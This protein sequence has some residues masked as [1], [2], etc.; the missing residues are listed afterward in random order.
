MQA[1]KFKT[2]K[3]TT[4]RTTPPLH[5]IYH[6]TNLIMRSRPQQPHI[7]EAYHRAPS[8]ASLS[9]NPGNYVIHICEA[10]HRPVTSAS[11][12]KT[13]TNQ[14]VQNK[15]K[16]VGF[17]AGNAGQTRHLVI[18]H[19]RS[20]PQSALVRFGVRKSRK[21]RLS[22]LRSLPQTRHI[23]FAGQNKHKPAGFT[24]GNAGQTR[25]LVT[26]LNE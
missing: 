3:F 17:T 6:H 1:N 8:C 19:P 21:P 23:R 20:L 9:G 16:P 13:S 26:L 25:H 12:D 22:H 10:Y 4:L 2:L 14:L 24:A 15:H 11:L 5:N 18:P 7:R